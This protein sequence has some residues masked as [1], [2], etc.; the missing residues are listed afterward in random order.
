[1]IWPTRPTTA[2]SKTPFLHSRSEMKV[3]LIFCVACCLSLS[4]VA[5]FDQEW[6]DWKDLHGKRYSPADEEERHAVWTKNRD[7]VVQH[8]KEGHNYTVELNQFADLVSSYT[9]ESP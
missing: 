6:E 2:A 3:A 1:M 5:V 9:H 4:T 8:N 7:F